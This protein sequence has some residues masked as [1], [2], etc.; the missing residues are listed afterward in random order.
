M[1]PLRHAHYGGKGSTPAGRAFMI[2]WAMIFL[3]G[4]LIASILALILMSVIHDRAV[5]L[6]HRRLGAS[7]PKSL[8]E[9]H[10]EKDRQRAECAMSVRRLERSVEKLRFEAATARAEIGRKTQA[11]GRLKTELA[12]RI[13]VADELA[14]EVECLTDKI[15]EV[16][17]ERVR[18]EVR[19]FSIEQALFAREGELVRC[20]AEQ[21]LA[22]HA[23]RVEIAELNARIEQYRL[24]VDQL[25][26]HV[27][28]PTRRPFDVPMV[29]LAIIKELEEE[30]QAALFW[31]SSRQIAD[32]LTG[33]LYD[34]A[35]HVFA[36]PGSIAP[37][38]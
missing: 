15:E 19:V 5:R 13:E 22:I 28:Y 21:G 2:E 24:A 10:V 35:D 34:H 33:E 1:E 4:F 38:Q 30:H 27:D 31:R 23:Q 20:S 29:T 16:E 14:R 12:R 32:E 25:R 7:L 9:M 17:R 18:N 6:T 36:Q 26:Q 3:G 11:I 8:V 37:A